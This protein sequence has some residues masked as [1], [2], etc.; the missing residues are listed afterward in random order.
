MRIK[1]GELIFYPYFR[2]WELW[3]AFPANL[4]GI[5]VLQKYMADEI[6]VK[7][8]L[9]CANSKGLHLYKYVE[10]WARLRVGKKDD[11]LLVINKAIESSASFRGGHYEE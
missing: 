9:I 4:G 6:G 8:G 3:G 7:P 10:E 2:S 11:K 1:N 5:A